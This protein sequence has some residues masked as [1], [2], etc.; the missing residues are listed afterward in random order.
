[1][2]DDRIIELYLS[3]DESA[4][5]ETAAKYGSR[6]RS[7]AQAILGDAGAAEECENDAYLEAWNRIP[8]NEPRGYLFEYLGRIVRH[9]AIDACRRRSALK[10]QTLECELTQEMEEC[11]PG[12]SEPETELEGQ[13][14]SR[15]ITEFL[16]SYP[17]TQRNLFLR[18]YWFFDSIAQLSERTG[19][20]REK[21]KSLLFRM[22]KALKKYLKERGYTV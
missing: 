4:L 19:F 16:Q 21:V 12:G 6:L 1:M 7:I 8:P 10:R 20:S 5:A 22:R 9:L 11:L 2:D 14:L 17:E 13:E 15:S 18:R 3:R